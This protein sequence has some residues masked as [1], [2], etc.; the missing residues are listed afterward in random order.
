MTTPTEKPQFLLLLRQPYDGKGS[1][2]DPEQMQQIMARFM[3]WMDGI[4]ARNTILSTNGLDY[5]CQILRGP[6]GK[7]VSDGPYLEA[8]EIIGGYVLLTADSHEQ[9]LE[10]ARACP[11]LDHQMAVEVRPVLQR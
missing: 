1:R 10:I 7:T 11:G 3:I 5:R 4:R 8:K 2:P 9:A 6:G